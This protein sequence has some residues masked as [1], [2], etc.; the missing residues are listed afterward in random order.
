MQKISS[1]VDQLTISD[2]PLATPLL[3]TKVLA[4]R[5]KNDEL[6]KWVNQ[7]IEGYNEDA[8]LPNYR[9]VPSI[10]KGSYINGRTK[11]TNTVLPVPHESEDIVDFLTT[12]RLTQSC[13]A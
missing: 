1:I 8:I 10:L 4:T 3:E 2:S 6:L 7:E 5:I 12:S 13:S 11:F 9:I